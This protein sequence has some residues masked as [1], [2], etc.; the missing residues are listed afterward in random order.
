[1]S[2][3][4]ANKE[5]KVPVVRGA[6]SKSLSLGSG[7]KYTAMK[8]NVGWRTFSPSCRTV[9]R[10]VSFIGLRVHKTKALVHEVLS[11]LHW[12][13]HK[14]HADLK[15]PQGSAFCVALCAFYH[16]MS[17]HFHL[18]LL[19]RSL[20]SGHEDSFRNKRS[21]WPASFLA[22]MV[23]QKEMKYICSTSLLL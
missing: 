8:P 1:M 2:T 17:H 15:A 20:K 6:H 12:Y 3:Q 23:N 18:H 11:W 4:L 13:L 21:F 9:F 5:P 22:R 16:Q 14:K 7:N 10:R 19:C